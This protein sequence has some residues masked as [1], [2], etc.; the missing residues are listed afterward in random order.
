MTTTGMEDNS[1]SFMTEITEDFVTNVKQGFMDIRIVE[2]YING[3]IDSPRSILTPPPVV[4]IVQI[5]GSVIA[6][7]AI[8][9]KWVIEG[10]GQ[11]ASPEL[12]RTSIWCLTRLFSAIGLYTGPQ[13]EDSLEVVARR[14]SPNLLSHAHGEQTARST[15]LIPC[16]T[17]ISVDHL[18]ARRSLLAALA[19]IS[20]S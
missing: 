18:P 20:T 3:C 4:P 11:I 19:R 6:W 10:E 12:M 9:H 2:Q 1:A 8:E 7:C 16:L 5:I 15:R 14:L 17:A 13:F